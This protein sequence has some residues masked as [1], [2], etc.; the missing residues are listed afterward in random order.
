M[1]SQ[2]TQCV[3]IGSQTAKQHINLEFLFRVY[4]TIGSRHDE[5]HVVLSLP[6]LLRA[7]LA[8]RGHYEKP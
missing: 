4:T 3:Y 1:P 7:V 6:L 8:V 5:R 2:Y